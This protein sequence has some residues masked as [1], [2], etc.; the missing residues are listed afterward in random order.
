MGSFSSSSSPPGRAERERPE[1]PAGPPLVPP[2]E[3]SPGHLWAGGS[4]PAPSIQTGPSSQATIS[5]NCLTSQTAPG[6][7]WGPHPP[8]NTGLRRPARQAVCTHTHAHTHLTHA[9]MY[10]PV[11]SLTPSHTL[12]T[13]SHP[14]SQPQPPRTYVHTRAPTPTPSPAHPAPASSPGGQPAGFF[15][16]IHSF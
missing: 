3:L 16:S 4:H 5:G 2:E 6:S 15:N 1:G 14:H 7:P 11:P 9:R 13:H 10:T 12:L 8:P